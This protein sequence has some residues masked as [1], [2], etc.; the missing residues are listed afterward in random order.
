MTCIDKVVGSVPYLRM[1]FLKL[2]ICLGFLVGF[3]SKSPKGAI[4]QY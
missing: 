1:L 3:W 2:G 4:I